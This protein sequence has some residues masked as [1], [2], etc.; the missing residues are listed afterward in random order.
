MQELELNNLLQ[1]SFHNKFNITKKRER[2]YQLF[3]PL[4]HNDGDMM[5]IFVKVNPDDTLTICD[6][7]MTLMRLSYTFDIDSKNKEKMLSNI[8]KE[9][10]ALN[11]DGNL[12]I[13]TSN[14]LFFENI[15]Q[16]SQVIAKVSNMKIMQRDIIA[17]MFY[18]NID[19]YISDKFKDYSP[20]RKF[21]PIEGRDELVV[22]YCFQTTA[23]PIY[24]FAI[25]G[26][27]KAKNS[28]ISMLTFQQES[29]PFTGVAVHEDFNALSLSTQK[30]IMN[31]ADKQFFDYNSFKT[32]SSKFFGRVFQ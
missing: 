26:N 20:L 3:L 6:C 22:D 12:C 9:G 14:D 5:D 21:T 13:N 4:Y 29:L 23:K 10:G 27:D 8:V 28:I 16:L 18:E 32:D 25:R 2:L 31:A 11:L 7:G 30:M 24:L 15:M 1:K 17:S 19:T